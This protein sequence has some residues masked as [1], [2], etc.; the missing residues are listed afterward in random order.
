MCVGESQLHG[1]AP[2][3]SPAPGPL[4][5]AGRALGRA[6]SPV[7]P[8]GLALAGAVVAAFFLTPH[9]VMFLPTLKSNQNLFH[10][11]ALYRW[12]HPLG[13]RDRQG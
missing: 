12:Q 10:N 7:R 9:V 13:A 5:R 4:K 8:A 1:A 11:L 6:W 3:E 2:G